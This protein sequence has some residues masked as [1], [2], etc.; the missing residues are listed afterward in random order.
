MDD[1]IDKF[2]SHIHFEEGM[3]DSM[4]SFYLTTAQKYV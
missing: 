4:L 2:K 3:D 1:L